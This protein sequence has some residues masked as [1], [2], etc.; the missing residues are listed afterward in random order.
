MNYLDEKPLVACLILGAMMAA[1]LFLLGVVFG[2][3]LA[4]NASDVCRCR[5]RY[6]RRLRG[7]LR[8]R[9]AD[10]APAGSIARSPRR[11]ARYRPGRIARPLLV[12][13]GA[14][15][16]LFFALAIAVEIADVVQLDTK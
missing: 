3:P 15:L 14:L 1:F 4:R 16:V 8:R 5:R 13:T 7:H 11:R 12:V 9:P 6:R 10:R 2:E